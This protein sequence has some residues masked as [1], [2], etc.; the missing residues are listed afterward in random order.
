VVTL[1][2]RLLVPRRLGLVRVGKANP[3]DAL[4][5]VEVEGVALQVPFQLLNIFHVTILEQRKILN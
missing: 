2:L 4:D 3:E 5:P 1:I